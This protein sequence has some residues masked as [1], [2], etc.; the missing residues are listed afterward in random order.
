MPAQHRPHVI[1]LKDVGWYVFDEMV[2]LGSYV[3]G[4]PLIFRRGGRVHVN[5]DEY[6]YRCMEAFHQQTPFGY[7]YN[8]IHRAQKITKLKKLDFRRF[9]EFEVPLVIVAAGSDQL[10]AWVFYSS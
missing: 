7:I 5:T 4:Q 9:I 6:L 10:I 3:S 1:L 8:T 2:A